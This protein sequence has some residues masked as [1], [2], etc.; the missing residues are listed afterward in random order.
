MGP[1]PPPPPS[2]L[3]WSRSSSGPFTSESD[4]QPSPAT[5]PLPPASASSIAE[6]LGSFT[7]QQV[8]SPNW[9][10][11][12]PFSCSLRC[13]FIRHWSW[14]EG[15]GTAEEAC[16]CAREREPTR[17]KFNPS[18]NKDCGSG[19]DGGG[20]AGGKEA[21]PPCII[22]LAVRPLHI[23]LSSETQHRKFFYKCEWLIPSYALKPT[24]PKRQQHRQKQNCITEKKKSFTQLILELSAQTRRRR[25]RR[26]RRAKASRIPITQRGNMLL[27]IIQ[28]II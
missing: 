4:I 17:F 16:C 22:L 7:A 11:N 1:P 26:R 18:R 27:L 9:R 13:G 23:M 6:L 28:K 2:P 21:S 12:L 15:N 25:R 3:S 10:C 8:S 19:G 24:Q 5:P 14:V 20:G